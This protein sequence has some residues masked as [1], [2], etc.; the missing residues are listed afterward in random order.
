MS[1]RKLRSFFGSSATLAALSAQVD[2]LLELQRVWTRIAP[3]SLVQSCNVASLRD[4]VMALYA[5]NGAVAAK[6]RQLTLSLLEKAKKNGVEVTA[7]SVR[8]QARP[9]PREDK[10]IKTLRFGPAALA[11]MRQLAGGLDPSPLREALERLLQRHAGE[12]DAAHG[13]QS[14]EHQ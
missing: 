3:P 5:S 7:I 1:A 10:P 13:D 6:V 11:S 8:V 12:D 14:A 2:H 9:L 4:G